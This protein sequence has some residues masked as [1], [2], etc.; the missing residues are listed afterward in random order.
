M[1]TAPRIGELADAD[2]ARVPA[3][4]QLLEPQLDIPTIRRRMA[5]MRQA[6]WVCIGAW[7][8]AGELVAIAGVSTRTHFFSG[9]VDFVEN[10]VVH[11]DWRGQGIGEALMRHLEARARANGSRKL[12]LD[13]YAINQGA[14]RF[15]EG[16]GYDP[17]GIHYVRDLD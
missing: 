16:L 4:V 5:R 15:Y 6:G 10:V 14:R 8:D 7:S 3:F 11:P 13:T 9:T 2:Y 12:T 17:R 1:V